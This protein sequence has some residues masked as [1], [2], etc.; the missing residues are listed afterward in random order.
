MTQQRGFT[1]VELLIAMA[2]SLIVI[3]GAITLTV[4]MS[5]AAADSALFSRLSQDLRTTMSLMARELRRAGFNANA[6][7]NIGTGEAGGVHG[8]VL[9]DDADADRIGECV[10]FGYDT[11]DS[12]DGLTDT[13][14]GVISP[15]EATE[16]RGFRRF[17]NGDGVGVLQMRVGGAGVG[18][19]CGAGGHNWVALTDP[20]LLDV[21]ELRFD[22]TRG[23]EAI[24]GNVPD[25]A[26]PTISRTSLI[27][28]RPL[29]ITLRARAIDDPEN[30]RELRQWVRVRADTARLLAAA[31]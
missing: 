6:L 3:G 15:A 19:G 31:P 22:L 21:V 14:P 30:I 26:D 25:P 20:D 11:L 1:L 24:G 4:N 12:A 2:I 7:V 13:T 16:W 8:Q 17:E 10:M 5:Q 18:N 23:F 9:L 27:S 28:V 29:Q